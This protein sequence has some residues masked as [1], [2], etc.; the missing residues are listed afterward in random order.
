M[1]GLSIASQHV[2]DAST[3]QNMN[4]ENVQ[5]ISVK[6]ADGTETSVYVQL[7]HMSGQFLPFNPPPIPQPLSGAEVD[8]SAESEGAGMAQSQEPIIQEP[9]T[10]VYKAL[11][12]LE[13]TIDENGRTHIKAHTP[14]LIEDNVGGA[15]LDESNPPRSFLQRMALREIKR[16]RIRGQANSMLAIS[17]KRQRKLKMKKKKYKKLMRRT[18]NERR[19]LDRV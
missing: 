9:Q 11:F 12:T 16:E 17:V 4:G 14:Q 5:S 8:A 3:A 18:R 10:R 13:E 1:Q 7:D 19:K 2:T 15:R 6:H